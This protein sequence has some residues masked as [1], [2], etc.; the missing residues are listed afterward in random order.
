M[1]KIKLALK[2][3]LVLVVILIAHFVII[4]Y[5]PFCDF[6]MRVET[7]E[8]VVALTFDDGPHPPFTNNLI[9]VLDRHRVKATFFLVG[10]NVQMFPDI[11]KTLIQKNHEVG[12]HSY[13]HTPLIYRSPSFV[14]AQITKT[15][16]VLRAIG[17]TGEIFFRS[18]YGANLFVVPYILS[19]LDKTNINFDVVPRDWE[20]KNPVIIAERVIESVKP[21]SIILLHD[22]DGPRQATVDAV[23][24]IIE[25]LRKDNYT[26]VTISELLTYADG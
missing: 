2:I 23:D 20:E 14:R 10:K 7:T 21:G 5:Q 22:G 16:S 13:S 15:D 4:R 17:V 24:I 26:F 9:S 11:A 19:E 3:V 8:R 12:N 25:Q 18:P 1:R 6:Y